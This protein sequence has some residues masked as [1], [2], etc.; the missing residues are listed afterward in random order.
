MRCM[1]FPRWQRILIRPA[2]ELW[3]IG[4]RAA[5]AGRAGR[6]PVLAVSAGLLCIAGD[7]LYSTRPLR[8]VAIA[9]GAVSANQPLKLAL[10]RLP[11]SAFLPTPHLPIPLAAMQIVVVLGLAELV[12][13]ARATA[14][15]AITGHI[16]STLLARLFF[17]STTV[18][19]L[20]LPLG[21]AR[22]LD[23]GPSG[24]TTAVGAWLLV[25]FRAYASLAMLGGALTISGFLQDNLDG[26]E[27][28]AAF[29]VG[30][31]A[32]ILPAQARRLAALAAPS[33]GYLSRVRRVPVLAE[34]DGAKVSKTDTQ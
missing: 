7:V 5:M 32:A 8:H 1:G 9:A 28:L 14:T 25:R 29:A 30:A 4:E 18:G 19:V 12:L 11:G 10:V 2:D 21:Q 33:Q 17:I 3:S 27:H 15:V 16:A 6:I 26:R 20:G 23:T 31:L 34:I 22:I 24:M 13:G